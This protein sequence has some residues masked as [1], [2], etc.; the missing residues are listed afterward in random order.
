MKSV[1]DLVAQANSRVDTVTAQ[2]AMP[3]LADPNTVFAGLRDSSELMRDGKIP[4]FTLVPANAAYLSVY[5][6]RNGRNGR[7]G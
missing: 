1:K 4:S 2:E 7:I 6:R 3:L 5:F